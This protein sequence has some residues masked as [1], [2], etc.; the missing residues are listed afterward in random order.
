MRRKIREGEERD[1]KLMTDR[2]NLRILLP[3]L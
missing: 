3:W 2:E 1:V